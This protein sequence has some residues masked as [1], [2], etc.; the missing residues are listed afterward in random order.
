MNARL[1]L[2]AMMCGG[3]IEFL[4]PEPPSDCGFAS[5]VSAMLNA[6]CQLIG[7]G[8]RYR[9]VRPQQ[10]DNL[11]DC[12]IAR[13]LNPADVVDEI[14]GIGSITGV[15]QAARSTTEGA[16]DTRLAADELARVALGLQQLVAQ[17][18]L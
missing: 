2:Q 10:T 11:V 15:A 4:A 16:N 13:P 6:G 14:H 12:A 9:I 8:T 3:P 18:K 5:A 1:Q 7:S 17:F